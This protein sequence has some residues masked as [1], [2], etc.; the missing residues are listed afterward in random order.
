MRSILRAAVPLAFA[1]TIAASGPGSAVPSK[2]DDAA[3]LHVLNRAGFGARPGDVER[4]RQLGLDKYIEQQLHPE[5]LADAQMAA[6]LSGF[7]TVGRSSRE[8]A[9]EY[10]VPAM[11]ARQQAKQEAGAEAPADARPRT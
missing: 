6:R 1:A 9:D 4:V 8:L 10:F 7:T 5:R 3:I 2:P 11:M